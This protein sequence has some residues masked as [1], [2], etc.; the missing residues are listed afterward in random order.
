MKKRQYGFTF[1]E[2]MGTLLVAS[3]MV[4]GVNAM[5]DSAMNDTKT[6][7]AA[8]QQSQAADAAKK[9]IANQ[10]AAL[11]TATGGGATKAVPF[12]TAV[13]APMTQPMT[14]FLP[15]SFAVGNHAYGKTFC[16][17]VRQRP[18]LPSTKLDALL[19]TEG[20]ADQSIAGKFNP[21][22]IAFT[23][24]A[25][26]AANAGQGGGYISGAPLGNLGG[27]LEARGA[28]NSW[29]VDGTTAPTLANFTGANCGTAVK[30][31]QL[32]TAIFYEGPGQYTTDFMYRNAVPNRPELNKMTT[33]IGMGAGS[34]A[35]VKED[36]PC[37][38]PIQPGTIA[39]SNAASA[40]GIVGRVLSCRNGSWQRQGNL[41][42]RNPVAQY[43]DLALLPAADTTDPRPNAIGDVRMV[44]APPALSSGPQ[45]PRPFTW[46]G[47]TWQ[48]LT[49]DQYGVLTTP[50]IQISRNNINK[51]D[52]CNTGSPAG[53]PP[54]PIGRLATDAN[55]LVYSC[56][57]KDA[58]TNVWGTQSTMQVGDSEPAKTWII[59]WN[60][61]IA[62]VPWDSPTPANTAF[63]PHAWLIY[64]PSNHWYSAIMTRTIV[65]ARDGVIVAN[66][67]ANMSRQFMEDKTLEAQVQVV[68]QLYDKDTG[69]LIGSTDS[70]PNKFKDSAAV[71]SVTLSKVVTKNTSGYELR[72]LTNWCLYNYPTSGIYDRANY[73]NSVGVWIEK[74]PLHTTW[75]MD[76][77]Y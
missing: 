23:D 55:G 36:D 17:L 41:S 15:A 9:Y 77:L 72:I 8:L 65:P 73:K 22:A 10:Y 48:A 21:N 1:V 59:L 27:A 35:Q 20:G 44:K 70:M 32:A 64:Y 52:N 67:T 46:N 71:A 11:L 37:L 50:E 18:P 66:A 34:A 49:A 6:Q 24:L 28:Y 40:D 29:R 75:N 58:T 51:G 45:P 33:P 76:L 38:A 31:G 3:M 30:A 54:V 12:T 56:Q 4:I 63:W 60:S 14:D 68:I 25:Y 43:T 39:V 5:I 42:W 26:I 57:Y 53:A 69:L 61:T 7:Q 2:L 13:T 16:L 19:I 47:S 62:G 74:T